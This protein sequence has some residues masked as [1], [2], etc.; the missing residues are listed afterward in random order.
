MFPSYFFYGF[1]WLHDQTVVTWKEK[2]FIAEKQI[3]VINEQF[4]INL[5]LDFQEVLGVLRSFLNKR[6]LSPLWDTRVKRSENY[7]FLF[8]S[9]HHVL[10]R[11]MARIKQ[12]TRMKSS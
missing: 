6:K 8:A 5:R 11:K 10:R 4:S 2:N 1:V 7:F 3:Q 9:V 12:N